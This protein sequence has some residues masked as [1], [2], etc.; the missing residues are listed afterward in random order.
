M[1]LPVLRFIRKEI[2]KQ[3]APLGGAFQIKIKDFNLEIVLIR[4]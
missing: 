3:A 4:K 1:A 2:T